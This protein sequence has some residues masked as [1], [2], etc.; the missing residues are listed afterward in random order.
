[1]SLYYNDQS[2]LAVEIL[3]GLL[4]GRKKRIIHD[5]N[6]LRKVYLKGSTACF[7]Y[8]F[9]CKILSLCSLAK[10]EKQTNYFFFNKI[11]ENCFV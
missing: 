3:H 11:N 1:M 4:L 8:N 2:S 9:I 5:T 7:L 6:K 10:Y